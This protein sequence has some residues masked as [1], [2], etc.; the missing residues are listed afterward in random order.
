MGEP[1]VHFL[2]ARRYNLVALSQLVDKRL[3]IAMRRIGQ[4]EIVVARYDIVDTIP[5]S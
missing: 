2:N 3:L 5:A 4:Q 1:T